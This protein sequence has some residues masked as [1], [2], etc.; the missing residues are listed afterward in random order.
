MHTTIS[1]AVLAAAPLFAQADAEFFESRVRPVLA[2]SCYSCHG[3]E[4][5]LNG[6]RVDSRE[7]LLQGG[8]RGAALVPGSPPESLLVRAIR[9]EAGL[10]MPMGSKLKA[11]EIAAIEEWIR[12]GAAWPAAPAKTAVADWYDRAAKTHW[13]FQPVK[14][15]TPPAVRDTA[16][17]RN[18]IDRFI[19]AALEAKGLAPAP[20]ADRQTL[21]RRANLV[22]TGLPSV[23]A[24]GDIDRLLASPHFGEHWARHWMDVMR[25]GETRGYEWNYEITGAWRYRDYLIRAFNSDVPFD[26]FVREHIAGDLLEKPRPGESIAGTTF[27]RLGEAGHDDCI[28]FREIALDVVDNQIDTLGKAFQGL[29]LACARCHDHKLDPIP[30]ADYYGLS[31]ILNSSRALTHTID[32]PQVFAGVK[33][34]LQATKDAIRAEL[35]RV[36]TSRMDM[37]PMPAAKKAAFDDPV[38]PWLA[39]RTGGSKTFSEIWSDLVARYKEEAAARERFNRGNFTPYAGFERW[40]TGG[41]G[42]AAAKSGDFAPATEGSRILTAVLP[43]GLHTNLYTD[44]WNG[45]LRSPLLPKTHKYI[46]LRLMG[47]RLASRRTVLDNCAIGEGYRTLENESPKWLRQD[48]IAGEKLPAFVEVITKSDNPRIPDRPGMLKESAEELASPRSYFGAMQ[49]VLHDTPETPR[50]E[51]SHLSRLFEGAPPASLDELA[52]RYRAIA[53]QAVAAWSTGAA[54]DDDVRWLDSLLRAGLLENDIA[55]SP[56]LRELAAAYREREATLPEPRVVDGLGDAGPGVDSRVLITGDPHAPGAAAPRRML[57]RIGHAT[58]PFNPTGSGRLELAEQI[59]NPAN[60]LTARV[61]VNRVWHHLFGRGLVAT[62]DN[63][64]REGERPSNPDLL[65]YL[66]TRFMNEGWSVKKLVRLI[67]TSRTFQ[68]SGVASPQA[69]EIDPRNTLL[70]HF[71][72]RRM[73]AESVR[74]AILQVSGRLDPALFGPS[75]APPRTDPQD[76]RRLFNGPLDGK[77]RRSVYTQITRMEGSRFLE[78]FDYPNPMA[79]RGA[80]DRTNVPAQALALLNDPFVLDQA[81]VWGER[82]AHDSSPDAASRIDAMFIAALGRPAAPSERERF[83]GLAAELARLQSVLKED[84]LASAAVWRDVAHAIFNLK[85]FVYIR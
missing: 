29:T 7:A 25:Y 46:S 54:T 61:M 41:L 30:T 59:A 16:W 64:G 62:T 13:S 47:G 44:R 67:A 22:L 32:T 85:E 17:P 70:H 39:M 77:G 43:A 66:A 56:K 9:H 82:L 1:L 37:L 5:Q 36:W 27:F 69:G 79:A 52:A 80:R 20:P 33:A 60:P 84:M 78:I 6:L 58:A 53:R 75:I 12:R 19:L 48:T 11:D 63:F 28:K 23:D 42:L 3:A 45:A 76:Y 35:A 2:R 72:A 51:L 81:R 50:E 65:D 74:D 34:G 55:A 21:A 57:S 38:F 18:E 40:Y 31:G 24:S 4:K 15:P 71:P 14:N 26:Q 68:Q 73:P 10:A 49:A 8:K 83:T